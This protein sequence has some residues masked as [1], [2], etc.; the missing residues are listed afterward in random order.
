M[1]LILNPDPFCQNQIS[2]KE[3]HAYRFPYYNILSRIV[4]RPTNE[5]VLTNGLDVRVNCP[6]SASKYY[7]NENRKDSKCQSAGRGM[8]N[9]KESELME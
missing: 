4:H 5:R 8:K 2:S 7:I 9:K 6:V 3:V 1:L